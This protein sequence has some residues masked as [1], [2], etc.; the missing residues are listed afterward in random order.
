VK[1]LPNKKKQFIKKLNSSWATKS[2]DF[3]MVKNS[4]KL[5]KNQDIDKMYNSLQKKYSLTQKGITEIKYLNMIV[6]KQ[7]E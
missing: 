5:D 2:M 1:I 6:K 4:I 7:Y 3:N